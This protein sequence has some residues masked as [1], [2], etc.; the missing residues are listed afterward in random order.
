[1]KALQQTDRISNRA[2]IQYNGTCC[3]QTWRET[4]HKNANEC[5]TN[6]C[7]LPLDTFLFASR[8]PPLPSPGPSRPWPAPPREASRPPPR[9]RNVQPVAAASVASAPGGSDQARISQMQRGASIL[10]P[11]PPRQHRAPA[12][13]AA[14]ASQN[15]RGA[16]FQQVIDPGW[17]CRA[18]QF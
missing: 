11:A 13:G 15:R 14:K 4:S 8:N 6:R 12:P 10:R 17:G 5:D 7:V 9:C 1:L 2:N 3:F 18:V 16:L